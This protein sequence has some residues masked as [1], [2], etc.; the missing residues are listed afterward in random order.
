MNPESGIEKLGTAAAA[1]NPKKRTRAS[2]RAPTTVLTTD[3]TNFR[4]M[5]QEF[6][7]I[8]NTPFSASSSSSNFSRRLDLYG[9][10]SGIGIGN[11]PVLR[12]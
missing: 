10:G 8:P 12:N 3:T 2:R 1:R 5:V 6:T 11:L 9:G 7:G 4:Q